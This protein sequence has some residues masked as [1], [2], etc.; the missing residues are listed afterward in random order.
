MKE[1]D[2]PSS[3]QVTGSYFTYSGDEALL[4]KLV[5]EHGAVVSS[6]NTDPWNNYAVGD[7]A[8]LNCFSAETGINQQKL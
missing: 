7:T 5:A 4:E 3:A 8:R 2:Q 6:V 1:T